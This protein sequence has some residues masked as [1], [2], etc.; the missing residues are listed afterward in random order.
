MLN[1]HMLWLFQKQR[2]TAQL[3]T[4][5]LFPEICMYSVY[6][7]DRNTH[8]GG[9]GGGWGMLLWISLGKIFTNKY[10]DYVASWYQKPYGAVYDFQL[11]RD[12]LV[13]SA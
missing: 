4:S 5:D 1:N 2:L 7:K 8:G 10:S 12:Q 9:G 13:V 3:Q 11:F 6:R